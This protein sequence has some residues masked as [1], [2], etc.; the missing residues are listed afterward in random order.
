MDDLD[1]ENLKSIFLDEC[2]EN[3]ELLETGLLRMGNGEDDPDLVNEV[4]RAAHSI[5]GGGATLGF[6]AL[7]EL[8]HHMETL[9]DFMRAG[10][11][12]VNDEDVDTLL[13]AQDCLSE[14]LAADGDDQTSENFE[15]LKA[16]LEK[17]VEQIQ[18][19]GKSGDEEDKAGDS[20][21]ADAS[22]LAQEKRNWFIEFAPKPEI[23]QRGNEPLFLIKE[24]M[25]L[26]ESKVTLLTD[27][28]P[29][30]PPEE[31]TLSFLSWEIELEST[32]TEEEIH[33]IFEWASLD[34][35]LTVEDRT[36][37][38]PESTASHDDASASTD[39]TAGS[40][41]QAPDHTQAA[42]KTAKST[43]SKAA[44]DKK[45]KPASKG[46]AESQTIRI[47]TEKVDQ[48]MNMVG[49]LVITQ[50]MLRRI[51]S[52]PSVEDYEQLAEQFAQQERNIRELQESVMRVRMLPVSYGFNRL[53]RLIRDL[54][55]K[56]DKTVDLD[57]KGASTELDKTVLEGIMDPLVH[58]VRNSL[59]HGLESPQERKKANKNPTGTLTLDAR[60]QGGNVVISIADDGRGINRQVVK[61]KALERGIISE[62]DELTDEQ[63]DMLIFAPGFSTASTVSDVSGRGVGMDVVKRNIA[64]LGGHVT[65]SS[66]PGE[67]TVVT[68]HL[69]LTLAIL[70]GQLV[71]VADQI[72][73]IPILSIVETLELSDDEVKKLPGGEEVVKF[74]GD[75]LP[76]VN[77]Q[78]KFSLPPTTTHKNKLVVIVES[79]GEMLGLVIDHVVGQQQVVIKAL[80]ENYHSVAGFAGATIMN[81]GSVALILDPP[82]LSQHAMRG[83]AA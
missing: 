50:S 1:L 26:G 42:T 19:D 65:I 47:A 51:T 62:S 54:S 64:D 83:E 40:A 56:L 15:N 34:C 46:N 37:L 10:T 38:Q 36:E 11:L 45:D 8:T 24:L 9:L 12:E 17:R 22:A 6:T 60:H 49:E 23:M 66:S 27:K 5:K 20:D 13:N 28:V 58:L 44:S 39:A 70:D 57:I 67:G 31:P 81:D 74:R 7:A 80:E 2:R 63:I 52:E 71:R 4:F 29:D 82:A 30:W 14:L 76:L 35:S 68:I 55:K 18:S 79:L 25:R 78:K 69:P 72:Y 41:P 59:D 16:Q 3:L 33:Q 77:L 32:A 75:Y 53:P 48:I 21:S 61:Q 73:V 43:D